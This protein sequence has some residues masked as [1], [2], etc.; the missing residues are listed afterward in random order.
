MARAR[1]RGTANYWPGFVDALTTLLLV[2][3]FLLV[4]F[5]L[6]QVV[7]SRAI[8][9]KDAALKRLSQ[10][11]L[12]LT[13]LLSM[14]RQA[15][16]DLRGSTDQL[17]A[18]LGDATQARDELALLLEQ[19]TAKANA[20]EQRATQAEKALLDAESKVAADRETVEL[21]LRQLES[22][23]RDLEA[24]R[25]VRAELERQVAALN[26]ALQQSRTHA[27]EL[28][29]ETAENRRQVVVLRQRNEAM[30]KQQAAQ[31]S[32]L[33]ALRDR[34]KELEAKL[35]DERERTQL[36]QKEIDEKDVRLAELLAAAAAADESIEQERRLSEKRRSQIALLNLQIVKLQEEL[37]R[38][39]ALLDV[40]EAKDKES[41][42]QIKDLGRRLNRALAAKVEELS[43]YR[44]EFFGRLKEVLGDRGDITVVG[45]RFVFQSEVLFASGSDELGEEGKEQLARLA[46]TLIEIA[47]KIPDDIDWVLRVD[48]HTDAR[49]IAT[50]RFASNWELSTAR[51]ISV[52]RFLIQQGVPPKR[53]AATGFAEYQPLD[54][55]DDEL[56]YR[57]NRRIELKL[58][59]R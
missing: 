1:Q 15:N 49:P 12:E 4:V 56:A 27:D 28:E 54:T 21:R 44:S 22:L 41:Q 9:G 16:E 25:K 14:E 51:A 29:K 18:Q 10:Q 6:A 20:L 31:A 7:L 48:G 34:S 57:R 24:L 58:T 40:A 8:T 35:G 2:I 42:A 19:M 45:D 33:G 5:V 26:T 59:E 17:L 30:E 37:R 32:E 3:I 46:K 43:R 39:G 11:V 36:A 55:S 13:E 50:P 23:R 53:L 38:I 52:V 47:A